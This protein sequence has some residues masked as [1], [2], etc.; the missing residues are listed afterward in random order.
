MKG[1]SD[2][3]CYGNAAARQGEHNYITAIA[4]LTQFCGEQAARFSAVSKNVCASVQ[5]VTPGLRSAR[6]KRM[7]THA[8]QSPGSVL[9]NWEPYGETVM[10]LSTELTP[11]ADH[12]ERSAASF[13][14]HERAVP[15]STTLLPAT[16]IFVRSMSLMAL[17]CSACSI[18]SLVSDGATRGF[19][20]IELITPRTPA[21]R[22]TIFSA[23]S[24]WY[25]EST[26]PRRVTQPFATAT[27]IFSDGTAASQASA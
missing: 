27:L 11:G 22:R 25:C 19:T 23:S 5:G 21:K 13:S 24:F 2:L 10:R 3:K 8:R 7:F 12:A 20:L 9:S 4:V 17:R 1:A 18:L 6:T 16:S 26:S 14:A 15:C